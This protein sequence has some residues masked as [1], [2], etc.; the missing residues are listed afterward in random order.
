MK[1]YTFCI[2]IASLTLGTQYYN[3]DGL[4]P[5]MKICTQFW[6]DGYVLSYQ[7]MTVQ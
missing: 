2:T 6:K 1:K 3:N 5:A 4:L 7:S